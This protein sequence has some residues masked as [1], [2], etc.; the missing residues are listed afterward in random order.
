MA[1]VP[2]PGLVNDFFRCRYLRCCFLQLYRDLLPDVINTMAEPS[3]EARSDFHAETALLMWP[4]LCSLNCSVSTPPCYRLI[5]L[6]NQEGRPGKV[7]MSQGFSQ[8]V[9]RPPQPQ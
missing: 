2:F 5:E 3:R 8:Y 9:D 6:R 4:R 1:R 7:R